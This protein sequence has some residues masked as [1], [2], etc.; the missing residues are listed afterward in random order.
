[1]LAELPVQ[2]SLDSCVIRSLREEDAASLAQHANNRRIWLNL[3]DT[4]PHPYSLEDAQQFIARSSELP[5]ETVFAIEVDS[6][7]VG[8]ISVLLREGIERGTG[9][10]GYWLGEPFWGRGLMTEAVRAFSAFVLREFELLRLEAW[11]F[12][13]NPGSARVLEKTGFTLEGTVRRSVIKDGQ[14]LDCKL[15]ACFSTQQPTDQLDP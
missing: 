14:V 8:T 3:R 11:A 1:M 4:F 5:R 15:Y 6:Q 13:G 2:I 12:E 10:L 7:A 9:E